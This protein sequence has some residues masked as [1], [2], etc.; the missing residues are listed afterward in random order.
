MGWTRYRWGRTYPTSKATSRPQRPIG[1]QAPSGW[2]FPG[3]GDAVP[4]KNFSFLCV[5]SQFWV[6]LL[7]WYLCSFGGSIQIL[8]MKNLHFKSRFA[9]VQKCHFWLGIRLHANLTHLL[10]NVQGSVGFGGQTGFWWGILSY[11]RTEVEFWFWSAWIN[12]W[13]QTSDLPHNEGEFVKISHVPGREVETW[14]Q[15]THWWKS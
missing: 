11:S 15:K 12:I 6:I 5:K 10:F 4:F 1:C 13:P 3:F 8:V 9:S 7:W 14:I 2:C